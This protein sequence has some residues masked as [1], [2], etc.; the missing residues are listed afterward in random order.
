MANLVQTTE[1]CLYLILTGTNTQLIHYNESR[2]H[3]AIVGIYP[4][5]MDHPKKFCCP[6]GLD[7]MQQPVMLSSV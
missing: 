5:H 6:I 7:L 1:I 4:V 3:W 2:L